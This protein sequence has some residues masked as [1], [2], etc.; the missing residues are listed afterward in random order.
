MSRPLLSPSG[1][2]WHLGNGRVFTVWLWAILM[3]FSVA[4]LGGFD[5]ANTEAERATGLAIAVAVHLC[6]GLLMLSGA[7]IERAISAPELR[8]AAVLGYAALLGAIRPVL[9]DG[10]QRLLGVDLFSGHLGTRIAT[11]VIFFVVSIVLISLLVDALRQQA[12]ARARLRTVVSALNAG[13]QQDEAALDAA[14]QRLR[15]DAA[16]LIGLALTRER[17]PQWNAAAEADALRRVSDEIVRPLSHLAFDS[18]RSGDAMKGAPEHDDTL[19]ASARPEFIK[20]SAVFTRA[21]LLALDLR[22]GRLWLAP[23]LYCLL[24]L[25]YLLTYFGLGTGTAVTVTGFLAAMLGGML[26]KRYLPPTTTGAARLAVVAGYLGVGLLVSVSTFAVLLEWRLS[27]VVIN[28][29]CY[30]AIALT[31]SACQSAI[32]LLR[33]SNH[34]LA[35]ASAAADRRSAAA[36]SRL[37]VAREGLARLLH[38]A[39]QG[40]LIAVS[41][42]VRR[43]EADAAAVDSAV[44]TIQQTLTAHGSDEG[45]SGSALTVDAVRASAERM[46]A[47]WGSAL[48]IDAAVE[49]EAW[50]RLA[51]DRHRASVALDV[52]SE[53]FSNVLRHGSEPKAQLTVQSTPTGVNIEVSSPGSLGDSSDGYGLADLRARVGALSVRQCGQNVVLNATID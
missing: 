43:G 49:P 41:L 6:I 28:L 16:E 26:V 33:A 17:P 10:A 20:P 45:E 27:T 34:A 21:D 22:P 19:A 39:V 37:V 13:T 24:F 30:P 14:M 44:A 29:V 25:P 40:E 42:R 23:L 9:I 12:A 51:D 31:I 53:A 5:E 50:V 3:P 36:H 7:A 52:V 8:A 46:L 38:T 11:N 15:R 1:L 2:A 4:I 47:A 32:R 18:A 48:T 35:D